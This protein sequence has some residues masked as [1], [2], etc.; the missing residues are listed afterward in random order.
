MKCTD[1]EKH[2][3]TWDALPFGISYCHLAFLVKILRRQ[4]LDS[5]F[6]ILS[7]RTQSS[8][9]LSIFSFFFFHLCDYFCFP[10]YIT[11][12]IASNDI[13]STLKDSNN[14]LTVFSFSQD[15]IQN[16]LLFLILASIFTYFLFIW[17]IR[18]AKHKRTVTTQ[19]SALKRTP[20][21]TSSVWFFNDIYAGIVSWNI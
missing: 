14:T 13:S 8:S 9:L 18:Y 2:D 15:L 10:Q 11:M 7:T 16:I 20:S 12:G 1:S 4:F 5:D 19:P 6:S 3:D 17:C 21:F